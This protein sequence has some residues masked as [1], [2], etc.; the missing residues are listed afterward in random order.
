MLAALYNTGALGFITRAL[1]Q[2]QEKRDWVSYGR[3]AGQDCSK[4]DSTPQLSQANGCHWG[5][6]PRLTIITILC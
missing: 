3:Q 4:A 5:S 6:R 2:L 1:L